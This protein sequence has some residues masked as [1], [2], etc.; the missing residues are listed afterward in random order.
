MNI[1]PDPLARIAALEKEMAEL[2]RI[3][4]GEAKPLRE[5]EVWITHGTGD[6]FGPY[7]PDCNCREALAHGNAYRTKEEAERAEKRMRASAW[8]KE[9]GWKP[10]EEEKVWW[11]TMFGTTSVEWSKD[12]LWLSI[13]YWSGAIHPTK[14]AAEKWWA[15]F[16]DAFEVN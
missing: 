1:K 14:E 12:L 13:A 15:E 3:V 10:K 7:G 8:V 9:S 5:C 16:G 6:I 11:V 4:N 2:K